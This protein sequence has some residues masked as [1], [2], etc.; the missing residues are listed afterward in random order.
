MLVV[1]TPDQDCQGFLERVRERLDRVGVQRPTVEVRFQDL[2]AE[3][4]VYVAQARNIPNL[5]NFVRTAAQVRT[6]CRSC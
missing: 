5:I 1:Q 2:T 3:A 4:R 6:V